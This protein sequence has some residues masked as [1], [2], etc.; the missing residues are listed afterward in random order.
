MADKYH[1]DTQEKIETIFYSPGLQDSQDLEPAT[2]TITALAEATGLAN[3]DYSK[4][5]TLPKPAD[6]RLVVKNIATK[7][8]VTID[9][10]TAGHLYCRVYADVQD[11]NHRL[12]NK[13]WTA[14]AATESVFNVNTGTIFDLLSDGVAHTFYFFFWVDAGNAVLSLV[15]F[16]EG[17]GLAG[18]PDY[19]L[20]IIHKG[21]TQFSF[22]CICLG[23]GDHTWQCAEITEGGNWTSG[24]VWTRSATNETWSAPNNVA[25]P[26]VMSGGKLTILAR[27]SIAT[28]FAYLSGMNLVLRSE[29]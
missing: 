12:Y 3:A 8:A 13:D 6:T 7:L 28:Q 11:A 5:L 23:A 27:T 20:E 18:G 14:A 15:Q 10:M 21:L 4:A 25:S 26:L 22:Y 2:K 1:S 9:S 16:W 19:C 24:I 29:Q 17:V